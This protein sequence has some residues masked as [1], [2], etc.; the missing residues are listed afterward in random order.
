MEKPK[1]FSSDFDAIRDRIENPTPEDGI[2][3]E[4]TLPP[5]ADPDIARL[6]VKKYSKRKK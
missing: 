5:S 1:D 4:N 3:K 2:A 6:V